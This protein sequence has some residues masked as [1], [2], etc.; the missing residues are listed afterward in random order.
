MKKFVLAIMILSVFG[1]VFVFAGGE[2]EAKSSTS[3]DTNLGLENAWLSHIS[4]YTTNGAPE[5]GMNS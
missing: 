2:T 1:M 4:L 3:S 5:C